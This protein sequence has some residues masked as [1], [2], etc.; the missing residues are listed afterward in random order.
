[1]RELL[2]IDTGAWKA[3]LPDLTQHF[4]QFGDRLPER[5]SHQLQ[6]LG[7]RLG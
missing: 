5:L 6:N 1:M 3:E 2:A 7:A 4:S